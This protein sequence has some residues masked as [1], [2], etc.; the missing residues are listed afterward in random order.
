MTLTEICIL[1]TFI[2]MLL[3]LFWT[4]KLHLR[5][6]GLSGWDN[7]KWMFTQQEQ[8]VTSTVTTG[9]VDNVA[10][11][12]QNKSKTD[13]YSGTLVAPR[14]NFLHHRCTVIN[15]QAYIPCLQWYYIYRAYQITAWRLYSLLPANLCFGLYYAQHYSFRVLHKIVTS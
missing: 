8:K 12:D 15:H 14:N 4:L 2:I 11:D 10:I 5:K 13:W 3:I 7:K 6:R 1:E 9:Y